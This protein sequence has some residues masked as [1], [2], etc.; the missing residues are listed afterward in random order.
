[1]PSGK[2]SVDRIKHTDY[3]NKEK[4][5]RKKELLENKRNKGKDPRKAGK[6]GNKRKKRKICQFR[7]ACPLKERH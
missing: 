1:M 7:T 3:I 2:V 4:N 5:I 6:K